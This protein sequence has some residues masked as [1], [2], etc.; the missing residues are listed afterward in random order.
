MSIYSLL[1]AV[2]IAGGLGAVLIGIAPVLT[3]KGGRAHRLTG[4][5]SASNYVVI[6]WR[7]REGLLREILQTLEARLTPHGFARGHRST[8]VNLARVRA[9]KPLS[10]GAWRITLD[11]VT[12]LVVSRSYRDGLLARLKTPRP[13]P[14]PEPS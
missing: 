1:L 3:R 4:R 11:S 6:H 12:E 10:D 2:H 14:L 13:A 7:D 9:L 5:A 8:L